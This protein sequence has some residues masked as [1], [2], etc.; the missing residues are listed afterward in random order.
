MIPRHRRRFSGPPPW[1]PANEPWPPVRGWRRGRGRFVRRI[2]IIFGVFL[3]F[4]A[5][6]AVTLISVLINRVGIFGHAS[7]SAS[8]A[9]GVAS[10][11]VLVV[12]GLSVVMRRLGSP[13]GDI[14]AAAD[15][16]ASGD[17]GVRVAEGG[18]PS[19]RSVA[20][21]FNSMA[22]RLQ[23]QDEQR[24]HLMADVAHELRTPLAVVQGRLEGLL[25]GVYPRDDARLGELLDDTRL[26]GRLV[27]D[28]GTLA[29]AESGAL[30]L[31][32]EPTDLTALV[33]DTATMF[34]VDA[35]AKG[36]AIRVES[37]SDIPPVDIDPVRIREVLRNLLSN[38]LRHSPPGTAISI[39]IARQA[40]RIAVVVRDTG[41][42]IA[43]DVL[44]HIFNRFFKGERSQGSGLGL[45]IARNLVVAHGGEISAES[46]VGEGTAIT[47]TLPLSEGDS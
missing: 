9:L 18:P 12:V 44:P 39:T 36:V 2:A 32:K 5:T 11:M 25:D 15:R 30:A 14:V 38:A 40:A 31:R 33:H 20:R 41:S 23:A 46:R 6:G 35:Q 17:F 19:L 47:F 21:A 42:G 3:F 22:G 13:L 4:S 24:R 28:L 29:N 7:S 43:P 26:L 16:V 37:P 34:G 1:W 27:E 10:A 45:T 8:L